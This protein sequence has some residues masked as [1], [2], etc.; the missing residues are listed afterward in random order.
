[1]GLCRLQESPS[2]GTVLFVKRQ[3]MESLASVRVKLGVELGLGVTCTNTAWKGC[4][5][6]VFVECHRREMNGL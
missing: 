3:H 2:S 4:G 6:C 1:M 5:I